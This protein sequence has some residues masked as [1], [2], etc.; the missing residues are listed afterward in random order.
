MPGHESLKPDQFA[1]ILDVDV[2]QSTSELAP[3]L[4]APAVGAVV[5]WTVTRT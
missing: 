5:S 1:W 2:C 4:T 3:S